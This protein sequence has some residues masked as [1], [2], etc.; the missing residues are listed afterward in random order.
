MDLDLI[1]VGLAGHVLQHEALV[2]DAHSDDALPR[3]WRAALGDYGAPRARDAPRA[4]AAIFLTSVMPPAWQRSGWITSTNWPASRGAYC[5]LREVALAG[6]QV[7]AQLAGS[8][9]HGPKRLDV[10]GR[11]RLLEEAYVAI[12][13]RRAVFLTDGLR[14]TALAVVGQSSGPRPADSLAQG[15]QCVRPMSAAC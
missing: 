7:Y 13:A 10:F 5:H 12:G 1:A 15:G 14:R 8:L 4:S 3:P 2:G 11:H 9:A 6:G